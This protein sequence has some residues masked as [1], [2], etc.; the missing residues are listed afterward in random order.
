MLSTL[1][2]FP[3]V[4]LGVLST[5]SVCGALG[6]GS[7]SFKN[8]PT[9]L[10]TSVGFYQREELR[11]RRWEDETE[12]LIP[13]IPE[14]WFP[15][16]QCF[17]SAQNL[18]SCRPYLLPLESNPSHAP[19]NVGAVVS[20]WCWPQWAYHLCWFFFALLYLPK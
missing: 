17:A 10:R 6:P 8:L 14:G 3:F 13:T 16:P 12:A 2:I 9:N 18:P 19:F 4:L 1:S 15:P 20:P 11:Q 7:N 5:F